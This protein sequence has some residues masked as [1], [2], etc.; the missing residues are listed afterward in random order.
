MCYFSLVILTGH[1]LSQK[2]W[3]LARKKTCMWLALDTLTS[4]PTGRQQKTV[5]PTSCFAVENCHIFEQH[6]LSHFIYETRTEQKLSFFFLLIERH[7]PRL[8]KSR[9]AERGYLDHYSKINTG[10]LHLP[11]CWTQD[12]QD[13]K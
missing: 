6:Q 3:D 1:V 10:Q 5:S 9:T 2:H 8:F 13:T 12:A 11:A 4:I 7:N